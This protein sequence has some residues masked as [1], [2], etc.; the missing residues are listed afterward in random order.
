MNTWI[1]ANRAKLLII[2]LFIF[3]AGCSDNDNNSTSG[4]A[5]PAGFNALL[6]PT[7]ESP[8]CVNCHGFDEG[9]ATRSEHVAAGRS[10][11]CQECHGADVATWSAPFKS[12]SFT[13]LSSAEICEGS[14]NRSNSDLDFSSAFR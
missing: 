12:F 10:W 9:N 8:R 6:L 1:S 4:A 11:D 14:K 3:L 7:F 2:A 13:G 5:S